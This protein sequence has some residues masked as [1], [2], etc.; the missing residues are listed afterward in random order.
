MLLWGADM[1]D[2]YSDPDDYVGSRHRG[3]RVGSFWYSET[4]G[5]GDITV[6]E[7]F[8]S[9]HPFTQLEAL[10]DAIS[11]LRRQY[12]VVHRAYME[13]LESLQN[14]KVEQ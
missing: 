13:E 7:Y 10:N 11:M 6:S 3:K 12:Q 1:A 5:E 9:M 14:K 4:Y 8:D 2:R